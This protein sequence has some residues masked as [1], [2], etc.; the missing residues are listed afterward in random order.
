MKKQLS[1]LTTRR[2][3]STRLNLEEISDI[4]DVF[5]YLVAGMLLAIT[6]ATTGGLL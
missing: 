5:Y 3:V 1:S 6:A 2:I 4:A